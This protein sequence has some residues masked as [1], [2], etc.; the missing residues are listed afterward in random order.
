MNRDLCFHQL[1]STILRDCLCL[2]TFIKGC[3]V[4]RTAKV[5]TVCQLALAWAALWTQLDSRS[6]WEGNN[7]RLKA[8]MTPF[9]KMQRQLVELRIIIYALSDTE[10]RH[11][12]LKT[13]IKT[14]LFSFFDTFLYWGHIWYNRKLHHSGDPCRLSWLWVKVNKSLKIS[15]NLTFIWQSKDST[16]CKKWCCDTMKNIVTVLPRCFG[17]F[18]ESEM[19]FSKLVVQLPTSSKPFLWNSSKI[20]QYTSLSLFNRS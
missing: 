4:W 10:W 15:D 11:F 12:S 14:N 17:A 20:Y 13:P 19:N 16:G 5:G 9:L 18:L 2:C 3:D 7:Y 1:L 6:R 8:I